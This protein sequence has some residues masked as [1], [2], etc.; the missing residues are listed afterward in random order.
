MS[1]HPDAGGSPGTTSQPSPDSVD[2]A[3]RWLSAQLKGH[4]IPALLLTIGLDPLVLRALDRWA[5]STR[6]LALEPD[7]LVWRR[8]TMTEPIGDWMRTGRLRYLAGPGYS[9]ADEAWRLFPAAADGYRL[10]VHPRLASGSAANLE[11]ARVLKRI[12]FG[13]R[14]N[15]E[16]RRRFAPTYL[17]N[18]VRNLPAIVRGRNVGALE[19]RY[20]GIPALIIAAGPSLDG[21]LPHLAALRDRALLVAVDT[22]MRPLLAAGIEPHLV[23]GVDPGRWN[24]RHFEYL[25]ATTDTHL[26][27]ELALAPSAVDTF[28]DRTFWFRVGDHQPWPWFRDHGLS[29]SE[30]PVWGSVLTAAFQVAH[31][32]GCDPLIFVGADL[33]YTGNRPYCRGTTYEYDWAT[34]V[35]E[36]HELGTIWQQRVTGPK[37]RTASSVAGREVSTTS[38]MLSFRD[39]IVGRAER[40]GRKVINATV[41]GVL[42]GKRI[43]QAVLSQLSFN[44]AEIQPLADLSGHTMQVPEDVLVDQLRD[45][46]QQLRLGENSHE[47]LR[48]WFDFAGDGLEASA[49]D[50]ALEA[51]ASALGTASRRV[52]TGPPDA[53]VG[54]YAASTLFCLPESVAR[55]RAGLHDE[56][57]R[58]TVSTYVVDAERHLVLGEAL[59]ALR[60][61]CCQ[62]IDLPD[63]AVLGH[64]KEVSRAYAWPDRIRWAI[65]EFEALLGRVWHSGRV[66]CADALSSESLELNFSANW[67]DRAA[68]CQTTARACLRLTEQ[69]LCCVDT[70]ETSQAQ[71]VLASF[72]PF[73]TLKGHSGRQILLAPFRRVASLEAT[74][75]TVLYGVQRGAV[76]LI[77]YASSTMVVSPD[78]QLTPYLT[79]PRPIVG[80]IPWGRGAL[81]W[82]NGM[83]PDTQRPSGPAYVM[84]R[85]TLDDEPEVHEIDMRP[86]VAAWWNNRLVFSAYPT[87]DGESWVGVGSWAPGERAR[88]ELQGCTLFDLRPHNDLLEM[89]S[90][91]FVPGRG[92]LRPSRGHTLR[93]DGHHPPQRLQGTAP[94]ISSLASSAIG[95]AS[96]S[97]DTDTVLLDTVDGQRFAIP[98]PTPLKLAWAGDTLVVSTVNRELL[99]YPSVRQALGRDR[100]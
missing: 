63:V 70:L 72:V 7:P 15:A 93:W 80:E 44:K 53:G 8:Q 91:D 89:A 36:G 59:R 13:A 1:L 17:T 2:A 81:A 47:V 61:I 95:L 5:P 10:V 40:S 77:P 90:C 83:A 30:L 71:D 76:C 50:D 45:L 9:G 23:V 49:L 82:G 98:G 14:A 60:T 88:P 3:W 65:L 68:L 20:Q 64:Q 21:A 18:A 62:I 41:G 33:A 100:R 78:G 37:V 38:S 43:E 12:V 87:P 19:N 58:E 25:R 57:L 54:S 6:V 79:W 75:A 74:R 85:R 86:V 96:A 56:T 66:G 51:A 42:F 4:S 52:V 24:A 16:A 27:S 11:A 35:S 97:P 39:W 92:F 55:F 94:I 34:L 31:L 99:L 29:V 22:A 69:W 48:G 28:G 84:L 26:V 46:Q 32:A 67:S 73:V